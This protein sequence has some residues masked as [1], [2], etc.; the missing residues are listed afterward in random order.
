M[1][2]AGDAPNKPIPLERTREQKNDETKVNGHLPLFRY[3]LRRL[4]RPSPPPYHRAHAASD[5]VRFH[6]GASGFNKGPDCAPL[7]SA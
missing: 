5:M 6:R 1:T 3:I 2:T 7:D 4:S